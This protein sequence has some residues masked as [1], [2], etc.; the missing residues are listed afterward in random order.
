MTSGPGQDDIE[1]KAKVKVEDCK[2]DQ[3]VGKSANKEKGSGGKRSS[4]YSSHFIVLFLMI[5]ITN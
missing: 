3:N 5:W 4:R 1:S 2:H